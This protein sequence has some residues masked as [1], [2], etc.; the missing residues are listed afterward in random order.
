MRDVRRGRLQRPRFL[1]EVRAGYFT[2]PTFG[3]RTEHDVRRNETGPKILPGDN[4][5]RCHQLEM[6]AYIALILALKQI[7]ALGIADDVHS[8]PFRWC[9]L[10]KRG[11]RIDCEHAT[12]DGIGQC[13][14]G[15]NTH[16][17]SGKAA[18][19]DADRD[20]IHVGDFHAMHIEQCFQLGDERLRMA[21]ALGG[22][23]TLRDRAVI[24]QGNRAG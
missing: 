19:A 20:A 18:G 14:S 2:C 6:T 22:E 5:D 4:P 11:Q 16:P 17:Q 15:D 7:T 8:R 24:P 9:G 1:N 23:R 12:A 3:G 21:S 10:G 13:L